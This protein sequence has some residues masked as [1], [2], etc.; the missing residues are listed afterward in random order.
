M[1]DLNAKELVST[2]QAKSMNGAYEILKGL[3]IEELEKAIRQ[4]PLF[5]IREWDK[6]GPYNDV[7]AMECLFVYQCR[8]TIIRKQKGIW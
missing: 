2:I 3:S 4:A 7:Y 5:F 1:T 6:L 8:E